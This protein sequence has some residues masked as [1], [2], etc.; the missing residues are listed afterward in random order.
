MRIIEHVVHPHP[1]ETLQ[2]RIDEAKVTG[3]PMV[4]NPWWFRNTETGQ[5]YHDIYGCLGYPDEIQETEEQ[6]GYVAIVGV[7][8]AHGELEHYNPLN[9]DFQLL[10]EAESKDVGLL[11][12]KAVELRERYGFGLRP[13]LLK[14][15]YGDPDRFITT[16]ALKSED[17]IRRGEKSVLITPPMDFYDSK[18]FDIYIR[19]LKS[20]MLPET[21]RFY[22]GGNNILKNHLREFRRNN[23]AVFAVGGLIHSLLTHCTWMGDAGDTIFNVEGENA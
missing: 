5:L 13:E 14:S 8:R 23:P 7:V 6:P 15:F 18:A 17:L 1:W 20:C 21:V 3:Q 2:A 10:A 16:L 11:V 22:F 4:E 12:E 19:S 9:A